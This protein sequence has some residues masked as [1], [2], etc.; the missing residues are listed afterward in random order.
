A[1]RSGRR[2]ESLVP[3]LVAGLAFV[4]LQSVAL[5]AGLAFVAEL[6]GG[7]GGD[8]LLQLDDLE[9]LRLLLAAGFLVVHGATPPPGIEWNTDGVHRPRSSG[10]VAWA[11]RTANTL[12]SGA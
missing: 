10:D 3:A 2:A 1:A 4:A 6:A 9:A 7:G 12:E 11:A 8:P 5:V